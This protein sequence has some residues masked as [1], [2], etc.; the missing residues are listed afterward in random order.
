MLIKIENDIHFFF[1]F[2]QRKIKQSFTSAWYPTINSTDRK[3]SV[4][5]YISFFILL[6]TSKSNNV[7]EMK[8]KYPQASEWSAD[9][10]TA[11]EYQNSSII[12]KE[13]NAE[14]YVTIK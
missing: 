6:Q 4:S 1:V 3:D 14:K 8:T 12:N 11:F 9:Y 7:N 13:S 2:N 10:G 5:S